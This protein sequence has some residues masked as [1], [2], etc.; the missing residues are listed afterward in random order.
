MRVIS[1][2]RSGVL[3]SLCLLGFACAATKKADQFA[4]ARPARLTKVAIEMLDPGSKKYNPEKG[5]AYLEYSLRYGD[6]KKIDIPA[7]VLLELLKSEKVAVEKSRSLEQQLE[8]MKEIDL[9][10]EEGI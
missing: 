2:S 10:R 7:Q 4:D 6:I 5:R 3:A 9:T 1:V 8:I